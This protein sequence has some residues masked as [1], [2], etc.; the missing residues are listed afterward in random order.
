LETAK[1]Y[2]SSE[3]GIAEPTSINVNS[4]IR[5]YSPLLDE[6][7]YILAEGDVITVSLGVHIDGY[8]V[9]SSQT[10]HIQSS[11]APTTGIVADAVCALHYATKGIVNEISTGLT[12]QIQ[13][14]LKEALET[15]GVNVVEGSYL[16]RI[17][18]FLV[19][20]ATIEERKGKVLEFGNK[21][22]DFIVQPG[23]VYLLDLAVSTS[24]GKVPSFLKSSDKKAKVHSDLRPTI[25]TRSIPASKSHVNFKLSATR[26]LFTQLTS[27]ASLYSVFPFTLRQ[28]ADPAR[29]KLGVAELVTH[30]IL[31]PCPILMEKSQKAIV[32]RRTVTIFIRKRGEALVL[33]G[34]E[35]E[36]RVMWV[37]SEKGVRVG[38]ELERAIRG[39]GVKVVE[40]K[41]VEGEKMDLE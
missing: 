33:G 36:A 6:E 21:N 25:Y 26:N 23:E 38:G 20:Q 24:T 30:G 4:C 3:R 14:I 40:L 18:R 37:R 31:Q 15:Y 34:G 41:R 28:H 17:R 9:F 5:W 10:I 12:S 2:Q 1:V 7:G 19:G 27:D 35:Q 32:V 29:A 8:A 11:P 16:R 22:D 13:D 39:E